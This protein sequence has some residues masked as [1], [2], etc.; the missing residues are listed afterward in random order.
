MRLARHMPARRN[1][2][3]ARYSLAM[4]LYAVSC[5]TPGHA[6][7]ADAFIHHACRTL[8]RLLDMSALPSR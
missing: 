3:H 1:T 2:Q 5:W 8:A 4:S 6:T 7:G